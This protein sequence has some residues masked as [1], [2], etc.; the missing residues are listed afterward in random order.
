VGALGRL[1]L[2]LAAGE[3]VLTTD[4]DVTAWETVRDDYL[5]LCPSAQDR[6]WQLRGAVAVAS[7]DRAVLTY[8]EAVLHYRVLGGTGQRG[9]AHLEDAREA[10]LA[11][12][13]RAIRVTAGGE[14]G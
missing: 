12:I 4:L 2:R 11:V 6:W 9:A 3:L 14:P 1:R 5:R 10:V 13:D 8:S 7:C